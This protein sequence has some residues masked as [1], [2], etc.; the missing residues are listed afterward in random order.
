MARKIVRF[1]VLAGCLSALAS[2]ADAFTAKFY[3]GTT[4]YGGPFNGAGTVYATTSGLGV[5]CPGGGGTCASDVISTPLTFNTSSASYNITATAT[6][7]GVGTQVWADLA[8]NFG[9]LGVSPTTDQI[10]SGS[11]EVLHL[12]FNNAVTLTG[13]GTLFDPAHAP[14]GTGTSFQTAGSIAGSNGFLLSLNNFTTS[15]FIS[16][17]QANNTN[18]GTD[19]NFNLAFTGTDFYFKQAAGNPEFYV[20]ALTFNAVGVPG[21]VAGAGLPGLILAGAGLFGWRRKKRKALRAAG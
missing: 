21:P 12:Q 20:S 5:N 10:G 15:N 7:S 14:F 18:Q 8:P 19:L 6:L 4:G 9:G 13:V 17:D 11:T 2:P 1:F 3:N 16:F